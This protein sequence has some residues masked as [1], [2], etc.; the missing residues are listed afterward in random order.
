MKLFNIFT[1]NI[2]AKLKCAVYI[3][4]HNPTGCSTDHLCPTCPY[5]IIC[6][7]SGSLDLK[8]YK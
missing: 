2:D 5:A 3:P 4:L 1:L 6:E 7:E 8:V